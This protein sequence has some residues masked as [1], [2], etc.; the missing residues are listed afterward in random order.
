MTEK[1]SDHLGII[2]PGQGSQSVGMLA[3]LGE[4]FSVVADVFNEASGVLGYDLWQRVQ[5]GPG[6]LLNQT[7]STQPAMLTAGVA[8]WRCWQAQGGPMPAVMAG[9]SLGEYTALVCAD[10]LQFS[11]AVKLVEQRAQAM[12]AAVADG[13]G[14]MAAIL[15]LDDEAVIKVC[16]EVAQG[17]VVSAVNFNSPGQVVIAGQATAVNRAIEAA[18]DAGA[19]RAL[20]LPVSVPSHCALMQPAAEQLLAHLQDVDIS[21]AKIPVLHNVDVS[22]HADA[23][24]I[25]QVLA[26]QLYMPVRW[27]DTIRA[28]ADRGVSQLVE[29]GPG[30]VLTGLNKRIDK[31]LSAFAVQD[32]AGLEKALEAIA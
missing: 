29:A 22:S 6:T 15:G 26:Q 19:K 7:T 3:E 31:K 4:A 2:F 32:S 8:V 23:A 5:Q 1:T 27:V 30:K 10:A 9:H 14:A 16:D 20:L 17:D 12:Q 13:E 18:K 24:D 21:S 11:D 28:M 25:R